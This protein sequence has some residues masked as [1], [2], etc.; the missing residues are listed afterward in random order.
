[1]LSPRIWFVGVPVLVAMFF[2]NPSPMLILIAFLAWP[3]L[4][5]AWRYNP[6]APENQRY[7][8][9]RREDQLLY[10]ASYLG[11]TVFLA[12]MCFEV[13]EELQHLLGR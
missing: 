12:L 2:Y 8:R 4:V 11:L 1:M 7:Y 10:G 13:H 5:V 3:Q 9:I 6:E